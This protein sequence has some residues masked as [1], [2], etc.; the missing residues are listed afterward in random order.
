MNLGLSLNLHFYPT[1]ND[2][3]PVAESDRETLYRSALHLRPLCWYRFEMRLFSKKQTQKPSTTSKSPKKERSRSRGFG[4]SNSLDQESLQEQ[5]EVSE[6]EEPHHRR[7]STR[8]SRS[9]SKSPTK[10][11]SSPTSKNST[12]PQK[13]SPAK[14]SNSDRSLRSKLG[15][16]STS[17]NLRFSPASPSKSFTHAQSAAKLDRSSSKKASLSESS[18]IHPLNLPPEEREKRRSALLGAG[19]GY[20]TDRMS[21][22]PNDEEQLNEDIIMGGMSSPATPA[23]RS[24][25]P[26]S[27]PV[28]PAHKSTPDTPPEEVYDEEAAEAYKATGNKFFKAGDYK[29]AIAEYTR[30]IEAA[31]LNATY[32][33]NRSAAYMGAHQY[34]EA[35]EDAKKADELDPD[36]TKILLRLA[37]I[38]TALGRSSEALAIY[39]QMQ[40]PASSKDMAPAVAMENYAKQAENALQEGVSGSMAIHALDQAE[41]GLG[42]A[43]QPPRKWKLLRGE[44]YLKMGNVNALGDAQ[45][46]AMS[47]LRNNSQD[48]EALVLRGRA[49]YA[50]GENE[51]ALQHFRQAIACDPDYREAVKYL[52]LVQKL[53]K[54][55]E[56]GNIAFKAGKFA[57]A[58]QLY[59]GALDIDPTNK[60]INSKILQNRALASIK[61][62]KWLRKKV[63]AN[64]SLAQGISVSYR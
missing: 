15:R 13:K 61:V 26:E 57:E 49:L 48:P 56:D 17:S 63:L 8:S 52:R 25:E 32:L 41:K 64:E 42:L 53:D 31:P 3:G 46:V 19:R 59:T 9:D 11:P 30:A 47:L 24:V 7:N 4:D 5:E 1:V 40:P 33:S 28:P 60:T 2:S 16:A 18:D 51:K 44:A 54:M 39:N 37:R 34:Q 12:S 45:N 58:V 23:R 10:K 62:T 22:D 21:T 38:Y 43:V 14:S 55:K 20:I 35:L 50:Q 29:K 6:E 27:I 36:N